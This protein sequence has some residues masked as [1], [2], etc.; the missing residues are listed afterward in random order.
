MDYRRERRG[1][2]DLVVQYGQK[3]RMGLGD[4]EC[5]GLLE[6]MSKYAGNWDIKEIS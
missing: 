2:F 1:G 5:L 4:R 3:G 6:R